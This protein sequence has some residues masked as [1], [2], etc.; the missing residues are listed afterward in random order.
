M[1]TRDI[2][3]S[4][5]PARLT[6]MIDKAFCSA[7]ARAALWETRGGAAIGTVLADTLVPVLAVSILAEQGEMCGDEL[8]CLLRDIARDLR[9]HRLERLSDDVAAAGIRGFARC[10]DWQHA[11]DLAELRVEL[12]MRA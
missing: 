2:K 4:P 3:L 1:A 5:A 10:M 6:G 12:R 9:A 11:A 7:T 8:F